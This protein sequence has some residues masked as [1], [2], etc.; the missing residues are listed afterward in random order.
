VADR[1]RFPLR[2]I[3]AALAA[4][5][6]WLAHP[7]W[8]TA[9]GSCLV[10]A[11]EPFRADIAVVLAGDGYGERVLK[12]AEL[13]RRGFTGKVLVSGPEG[14]YGYNEAELAIPF[15]VGHGYPESWFLP[16]PNKSLSTREEAAVVAP[17]LRRR[18]VRRC[19]LVTSNYHTRRAGRIFR[20]AAPDVIFRVIAAED[21]FFRPDGWWR[22]REG[23]KR[24]VLEWMKTIAGWFGV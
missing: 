4:A 1:N 22:T 21:R 11:E 13:V 18:G 16:L 15:A 7:L 12:G 6:V 19:L 3:L 8:M 2:W 10:R 5:A 9:L 14:M 24:F 17:E 20:S 23:Q